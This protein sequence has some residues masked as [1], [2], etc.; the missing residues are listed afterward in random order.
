MVFPAKENPEDSKMKIQTS[1]EDKNRSNAWRIVA[2]LAKIKIQKQDLH[3]RFFVGRSRF[4][5]DA[6]IAG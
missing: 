2:I 1:R 4:A 5:K 6:C 3:G